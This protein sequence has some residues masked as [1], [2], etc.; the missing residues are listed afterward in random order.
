MQEP[1]VQTNAAHKVCIWEVSHLPQRPSSTAVLKGLLL[2]YCRSDFL[3]DAHL[4]PLQYLPLHVDMDTM[5]VIFH[6]YIG[7]IALS[8]SLPIQVFYSLCASI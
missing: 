5:P 8:T 6:G 2:P 3:R 4:L 7:G 1:G